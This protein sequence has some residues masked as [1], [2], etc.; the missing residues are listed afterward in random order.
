MPQSEFPTPAGAYSRL[1]EGNERFVGDVPEHPNQDTS[2]RQ[3]LATS[4]APFATLFGCADSRVA[5]EMIFDVGLGE[6]FVVR[7]AG[8]VTDAVT[9]GSL[10]YGVEVLG[11]PLLIVL[12]H[13]SC[14]AVTAAVD[15]FTTGNTPGG[16]IADVVA[17]LLPSVVRAQAKGIH[18]VTG[19]VEQNTVDTVELLYNRSRILRDAVDSGRLVM[20]GMTYHLEDGRVKVVAQRPHEAG[21]ADAG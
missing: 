5:A 10:E 7:T 6:M 17:Q 16:F 18:D 4:Q 14:G 20:L 19:T 9:I 11:T 2:R 15:S 8:Q 21:E 3:S 12:G 1:L 13:D